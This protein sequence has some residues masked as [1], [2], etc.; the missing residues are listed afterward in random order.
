M[1][2]ISDVEVWVSL[3]SPWSRLLRGEAWDEPA[4]TKHDEGI[5]TQ[6]NSTS[7]GMHLLRAHS[8]CASCGTVSMT[9]SGIGR[10][11]NTIREASCPC[12]GAKY[13][14]AMQTFLIHCNSFFAGLGWQAPT[15]TLRCGDEAMLRIKSESRHSLTSWVLARSSLIK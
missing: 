8:R 10:S 15:S 7:P 11:E 3:E 5:S 12:Y 6:L 9:H 1:F 4:W 2:C 13:Y 14:R